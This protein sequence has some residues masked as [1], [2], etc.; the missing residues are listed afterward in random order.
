[1]ID[2]TAI[3]LIITSARQV[4]L[5]KTEKMIAL[6]LMLAAGARQADVARRLGISKSEV[7]RMYARLC[8]AVQLGR[9]AA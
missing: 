9:L 3:L 8:D 1:V 7:S 2:V 6:G 4:E 5:N